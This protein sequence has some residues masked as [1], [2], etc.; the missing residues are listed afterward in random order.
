[1]LDYR[2]MDNHMLE[3][4]IVIK[5]KAWHMARGSDH[6]NCCIVKVLCL[7]DETGKENIATTTCRRGGLDTEH[8]RKNLLRQRERKCGR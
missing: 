8:S 1:M 5:V 4:L 3:D 2:R 7:V 6:H